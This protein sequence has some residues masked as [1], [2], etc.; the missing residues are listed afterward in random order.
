MWVAD[1]IPGSEVSLDV[2]LL[3]DVQFHPNHTEY[4]WTR[5][6]L[7]RLIHQRKIFTVMVMEPI[8]VQ[9][10]ISSFLRTSLFGLL[11]DA[12]VQLVYADDHVRLNAFMELERVEGVRLSSDAGEKRL[13]DGLKNLSETVTVV[14]GSDDEEHAPRLIPAVMFRYCP[15][16][17]VSN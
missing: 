16:D 15:H 3:E 14:F 11:G 8:F 10:D 17:C 1:Q 13:M 2:S 6:E 5:E 12:P 7:Q 4:P 9:G